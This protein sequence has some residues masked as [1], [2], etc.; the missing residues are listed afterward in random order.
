MRERSGTLGSQSA[1]RRSTSDANSTA[2][3]HH[4]HEP[5]FDAHDAR[6]RIMRFF[7]DLRTALQATPDQVAAH[8]MIDRSAI[9]ALESGY[10][11]YLPPWNETA[12]F[13]MDYTALANVD[14]RPVLSAIAQALRA[15]GHQTSQATRTIGR[16]AQR[17]RPTRTLINRQTIQAVAN[18][19]T[20]TQRRAAISL[21]I[22]A[23]L[24]MST[25]NTSAMGSVV[26]PVQS[27]VSEF[28]DFFKVYFAPT[29]EGHRWIDVRDP[30]SRRGDRLQK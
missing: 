1:S 29:D 7:I 21:V 2:R 14:G 6:M 17:T 24:V 10:I 27:A 28:S 8:L 5:T 16:P 23:L 3:T 30:R 11:E 13:V 26:R 19:G 15:D 25:W 22:P 18:V 9:E 4:H 12:R 20:R